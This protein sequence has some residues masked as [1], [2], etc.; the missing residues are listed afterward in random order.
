[1]DK[2]ISNLGKI[3]L[4]VMYHKREGMQILMLNLALLFKKYNKI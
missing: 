4:E 2:E 3:C 1:M